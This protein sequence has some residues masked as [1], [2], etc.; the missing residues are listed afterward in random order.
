VH[1]RRGGDRD[2]H[3]KSELTKAAA[4]EI[5]GLQRFFAGCPF[6]PFGNREAPEEEPDIVDVSMLFFDTVCFGFLISRFDLV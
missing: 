4:V 5:P 2:C 3:R 1:R 6:E